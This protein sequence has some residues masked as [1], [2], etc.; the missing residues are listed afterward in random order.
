MGSQQLSHKLIDLGFFWALGTSERPGMT[1]QANHVLR[2]IPF[3]YDMNNGV[4]VVYDEK[5]RPW[6]R[7]WGEDSK[8]ATMFFE[9]VVSTHSLE[10]GAYVPH[11]NDGGWFVREIIPILDI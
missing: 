8:I 11:S 6:I 9:E 1:E 2:G 7:T 3:T 4:T 10:R 5:G